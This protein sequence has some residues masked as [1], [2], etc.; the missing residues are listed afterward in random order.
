MGG[1]LVEAYDS[2]R[3]KPLTNIL[4]HLG[5]KGTK[6]LGLHDDLSHQAIAHHSWP[7]LCIE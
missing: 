1:A 5:A 6:P 7:E 3:E 2:L 4:Q